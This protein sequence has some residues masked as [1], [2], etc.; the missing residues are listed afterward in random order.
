VRGKFR[1]YKI[2]KLKYITHFYTLAV[3]GS[4]G[5]TLGYRQSLTV[6]GTG[7][8]EYLIS[9]EKLPAGINALYTFFHF[10]SSSLTNLGGQRSILDLS[11]AP[12]PPP[13]R[14]LLPARLHLSTSWPLAAWWMRSRG[15]RGCW[16]WQ[17]DIGLRRHDNPSMKRR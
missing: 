17:Q 15:G 3:N 10:S 16:E 2:K 1:K 7:P 11:L 14:H 5:Q 9:S 12:L 8:V 13:R 6:N 4:A